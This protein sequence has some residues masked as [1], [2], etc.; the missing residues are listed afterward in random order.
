MFAIFPFL[1]RSFERLFDTRSENTLNE[2]ISYII[3]SID[4]GLGVTLVCSYH[5]R[6]EINPLF[7]PVEPIRRSDNKDYMQTEQN[8]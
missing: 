1:L 7:Q 5:D 8:V 3:G 2:I 4:T 6:A